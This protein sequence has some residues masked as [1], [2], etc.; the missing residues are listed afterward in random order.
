MPLL[1][2]Y[3][4]ATGGWAMGRATVGFLIF[5]CE[6]VYAGAFAC[7]SHRHAYNAYSSKERSW[8][9]LELE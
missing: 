3:S 5:L 1:K 8:D 4:L 7:V 6:C 2:Q 9:P